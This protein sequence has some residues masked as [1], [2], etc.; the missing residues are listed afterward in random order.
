MDFTSCYALVT[1]ETLC[2][3]RHDFLRKSRNDEVGR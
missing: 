1:A 2:C 3:R